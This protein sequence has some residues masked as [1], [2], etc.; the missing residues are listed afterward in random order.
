MSISFEKGVDQ[1]TEP[2]GLPIA[3][4]DCRQGAELHQRHETPIHHGRD[5][6]T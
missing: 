2:Y 3:P 6:E 1:F 5:N 4:A